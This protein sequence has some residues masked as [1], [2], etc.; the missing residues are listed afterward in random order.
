[1]SRYGDVHQHS[2]W[3]LP[4]PQARQPGC[5]STP[6]TA[7]W[8]AW[9]GP[10]HVAPQADM[11]DYDAPKAASGRA[12]RELDIVV[13]NAGVLSYG[14][15]E[16]PDSWTCQDMNDC[17]AAGGGSI[18]FTS[19]VAGLSGL[20]ALRSLHGRRRPRLS[21]A[22]SAPRSVPL[23]SLRSW[24]LPGRGVTRKPVY[25]TASI[26]AS[27][28]RSSIASHTRVAGTPNCAASGAPSGRRRGRG[29]HLQDRG[30]VAKR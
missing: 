30:L 8:S 20:P 7:R 24:V 2:A 21:V 25:R 18:V 6:V 26:S 27:F 10:R 29:R 23:S 16:R 4:G 17:R 22:P 13:A 5:R 19:S 15:M 9:C 12:I 28:V 3:V 11:S 1:V 14:R